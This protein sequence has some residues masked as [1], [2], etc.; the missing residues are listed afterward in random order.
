M[1]QSNLPK[2]G[3][4]R[5]SF[6]VQS[7]KPLKAGPAIS[8]AQE[9]LNASHF[10]YITAITKSGYEITISGSR[11]I[12]CIIFTSDTLI[13]VQDLD[14]FNRTISEISIQTGWETNCIMFYDRDRKGWLI[15]PK[16]LEEDP[17]CCFD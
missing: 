12:D 14:L 11:W 1:S 9:F 4:P 17:F 3:Q 2:V 16:H 7:K 8:I 13:P 5:A 10:G 15:R 6:G